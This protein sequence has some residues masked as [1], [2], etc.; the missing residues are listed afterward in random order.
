MTNNE[1][2]GLFTANMPLHA[3]FVQLLK[4]CTED[5]KKLEKASCRLDVINTDITEQ[6]ARVM[7]QQKQ[8]LYNQVQITRTLLDGL[9]LPEDDPTHEFCKSYIESLKKSKKEGDNNDS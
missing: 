3:E 5:K 9:D 4:E 2:A 6:I 8:I 7:T 1:K